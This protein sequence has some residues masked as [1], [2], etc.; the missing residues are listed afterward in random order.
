[1]AGTSRPSFAKRQKERAR[2]E[3]R[4]EK[5]QRKAQRSA[6]KEAS[7]AREGSGEPAFTDDQQDQPVGP[8]PDSDDFFRSQAEGES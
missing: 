6:E 3:K 5:A 8:E 1:M 2:Q 4:A 7:R